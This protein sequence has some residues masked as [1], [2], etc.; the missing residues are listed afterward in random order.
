MENEEVY[1]P[2]TQSFLGKFMKEKKK[3]FP[4]CV[5]ILLFKTYRPFL[6]FS[7]ILEFPFSKHI[8]IFYSGHF[9]PKEA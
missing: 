7:S 6:S 3:A 9:A 1:L 2:T 8:W 5:H 4:F